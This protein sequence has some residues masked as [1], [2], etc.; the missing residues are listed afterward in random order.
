MSAWPYLCKNVKFKFLALASNGHSHVTDGNW[1]GKWDG[2]KFRHTTC[3]S[4]GFVVMQ[5]VAFP[6]VHAASNI[7]FFFLLLRAPSWSVESMSWSYRTILSLIDALSSLPWSLS[8]HTF[9]YVMGNA[10]RASTLVCSG[11]LRALNVASHMSAYNLSF[12]QSSCTIMG[13]VLY[14]VLFPTTFL[15]Y[16]PQGPRLREVRVTCN[17]LVHSRPTY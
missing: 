13:N 12:Q 8:F 3:C 2:S 17:E 14:F 6:W 9:S 16:P 10:P 1:H 5:W 15:S 7:S 11:Y 4:W